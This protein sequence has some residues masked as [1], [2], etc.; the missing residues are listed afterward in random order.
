MRVATLALALVAV[1]GV[2]CA[3]IPV[4]V[5]RAVSNVTALASEKLD[6]NLLTHHDLECT[7]ERRRAEPRSQRWLSPCA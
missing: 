7:A 5:R 6:L 3:P 2:L 1:S 4:F